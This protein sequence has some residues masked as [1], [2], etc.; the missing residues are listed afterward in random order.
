MC[1]RGAR[2]R[3]ER[4]EVSGEDADSSSV[5][6]V[7]PRWR[8][9]RSLPA[10]MPVCRGHR[11]H[12]TDE[13][14]FATT[15]EEVAATLRGLSVAGAMPDVKST[16]HLDE[17]ILGPRSEVLLGWLALASAGDWRIGLEGVR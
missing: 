5:P 14:S 2:R 4:S 15:D 13:S 11:W 10:L 7:R 17:G 12:I 16:C 9:A 3:H 6:Q 1:E 8:R